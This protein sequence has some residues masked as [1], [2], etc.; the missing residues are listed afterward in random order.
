MTLERTEFLKTFD[1]NDLFFRCFSPRGNAR[2]EGLV[3]AV[4]GFAEHSGRYAEVAEAVCNKGMA[5]A[6]FDLRGHGKSGPRRGDAENLHA[7]I[8]DVL[9]VTNHAKSFLG[10]SKRDDIFF[11]L[12]GH[13]FGALLATYAASIL[14]DACPPLFL[15]SPLYRVLQE[16]PHWKKLAARTLPR[17]APLLPVPIGIDPQNISISQENIASYVA[18]ELNLFSITARFGELFLGA[19][20]ERDINAALA[21]IKAPV[22]MCIGSKD[23]LVDTARVKQVFPLLGSRHSR[24]RV[25]E[26]AGHEIFNET[27]ELRAEATAELMAW[28]DARGVRESS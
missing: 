22:T 8:L 24:L 14:H 12:L 5:F 3:L 19:V 15:S 9:F 4:H 16:V 28:I 11:G 26:G 10:L 17:L 20:N 7:M 27:P 2:V 21:R 23:T 18:D 25:I 13:S 6:S 1:G